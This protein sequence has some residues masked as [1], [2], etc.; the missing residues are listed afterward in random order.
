MLFQV[1]KKLG[2]A[3]VAGKN[4]DRARQW[5]GAFGETAVRAGT[6]RTNRPT[7]GQ[8]RYFPHNVGIVGFHDF[9]F[10][11]AKL[12]E[13]FAPW[14]YER[15]QQLH[16]KVR[17]SSTNLTDGLRKSIAMLQRRAPG[18]ALSI[19]ALTDG[20]ANAETDKLYEVV[21]DAKQQGI[22][23]YSIGF[24]PDADVVFLRRIAEA[25]GGW[26]NSP[27]SLRDLSAALVA[28]GQETVR[29][30]RGHTSAMVLAIDCSGSMVGQCEGGSTKIQA[31]ERS[32]VDL[33]NWYQRDPH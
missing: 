29:R 21:A 1:L 10:P 28:T 4:A 24:G 3:F 15:S 27:Q 23:I 22:K 5:S 17:G 19:F 12:A 18:M 26:F 11:V 9:G 31:V 6:P 25:T 16:N 20:L 33:I 30:S 7:K 8:K 13:P 2:Q 14:I 32:I